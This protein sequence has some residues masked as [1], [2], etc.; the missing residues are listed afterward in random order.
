MFWDWIIHDPYVA[1]EI[2]GNLKSKH[3]FVIFVS[4]S[5]HFDSSLIKLIVTCNCEWLDTFWPRVYQCGWKIMY[6]IRRKRTKSS[7]N[8]YKAL[9]NH[10]GLL[11]IICFINRSYRMDSS[12]R[13]T[14]IRAMTASGCL[15]FYCGQNEIKSDIHFKSNI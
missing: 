7:F 5:K 4:W 2:Y 13:Y 8:Q 6:T 14:F 10:H 1:D 15:M 11:W 12:Y 3:R 9:R